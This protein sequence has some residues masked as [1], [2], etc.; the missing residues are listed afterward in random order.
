MNHGSVHIFTPLSDGRLWVTLLWSALL[1][2]CLTVY[3][4]S[5]FVFS[6]KS[7]DS[8]IILLPHQDP[9]ERDRN[10]DIE[11]FKLDPGVQEA[12]WLE[13]GEVAR[14]IEIAFDDLPEGNLDVPGESWIPWMLEIR[15][16][17]P[18]SHVRRVRKFIQAR[19]HEGRWTVVADLESLRSL[20]QSRAG[21]RKV[22]LAIVIFIFPSGLFALKCLSWNPNHGKMIRLWSSVFVIAILLAGWHIMQ[23]S[24]MLHMRPHDL[25]WG[26]AFG[27]ILATWFAPMIR[28]KTSETSQA[29]QASEG[30]HE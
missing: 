12:R 7:A 25:I 24:L 19:R 6:Q 10:S 30:Y 11:R 14:Q 16:L 17:E 26:L 23:E 1:A 27:F 18:L 3:H 22:L 20:D 2:M 15:L 9:D 29:D 4:V 28:K 21:I 8:Q 5:E 13:P